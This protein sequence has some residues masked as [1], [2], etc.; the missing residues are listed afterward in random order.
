MVIDR[1]ALLAILGGEP[2]GAVFERS[3]RIAPSRLIG[4]VRLVETSMASV[5][6]LF[7]QAVAGAASAGGV[8]HQDV[9]S[10]E[11]VDVSESGVL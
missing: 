6:P 3:I 9:A 8:L 4:A 7:L 1:S 10:G 5:A 2:V 11:I